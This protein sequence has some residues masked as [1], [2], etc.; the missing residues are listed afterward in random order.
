MC[1]QEKATKFG[2]KR[3]EP[4][5]LKME[6]PAKHQ[7][8]LKP[9]TTPV[10]TAKRKHRC[11]TPQAAHNHN[12]DTWKFDSPTKGGGGQKTTWFVQVDGEAGICCREIWHNAGDG[13]DGGR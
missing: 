2:T 13:T 11:P 6:Q 7:V 10:T 12:K 1:C 4:R 8:N 3:G 9:T 5:R